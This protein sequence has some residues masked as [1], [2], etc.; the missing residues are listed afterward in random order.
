MSPKWGKL[1][2]SLLEEASEVMSNRTCNDWK[3]PDDWTLEERREFAEA[4]QID[5]NPSTDLSEEDSENLWNHEYGP[6]DWWV[7]SF[8]AKKLQEDKP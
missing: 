5:N 8:L 6:D 2:G 1:A 4:M 3:W 7:M